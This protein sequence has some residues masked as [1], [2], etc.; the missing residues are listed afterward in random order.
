MAKAAAESGIRQFEVDCG[1]HTA[2]GNIGKKVEWIANTG[3]WLVDKMKF[4]N[5]L[6][7]VFDTVRKLGMEPGLWISVGSA[8]SASRVFKDH[9][10]WAMLDKKGLPGNM[11]DISDWDLNTMCF[12]TGWK[13][14]IKNKILELVKDYGLKFV[15]LDLS[16]ITSAYIIDPE[17]SGCYATN[18]PNHK[19]RTESFIVIYDPLRIDE[20]PEE[21]TGRLIPGQWEGDLIP[22]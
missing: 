10:E 14:Y 11:H 18:H 21:V 16:V 19:D 9:P 3:D 4:P 1:W 15:K 5:G 6:K 20:C 8:A 2:Y 7:P 22:G 17:R 12:G 13:D